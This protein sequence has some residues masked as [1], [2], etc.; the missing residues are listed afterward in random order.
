M[1]AFTLA[2]VIFLTEA[3]SKSKIHTSTPVFVVLV[4]AILDWSGDQLKFANLG[5]SGSP[6]TCVSWEAEV[7]FILILL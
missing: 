7:G 3:F 2:W 1:L 4:T 5:F 6:L